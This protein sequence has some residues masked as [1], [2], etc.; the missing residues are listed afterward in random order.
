MKNSNDTIGNQTYDLPAC[1]AVPEP[2]APPHASSVFK[3]QSIIYNDE[4]CGSF[5]KFCTLYVFSLK[6]NLFYK[7]RVH[8]QV[9]SLD[10]SVLLKLFPQSGFFNSG[11]KSKSGGLMSGLYCRWGSTCHPY[12]SKIS[13]TAPEA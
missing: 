5:Q 9:S 3:H 8:T 2:T 11:N 4:I 13:Y 7:I 6:M 1:S 10:T 12:F